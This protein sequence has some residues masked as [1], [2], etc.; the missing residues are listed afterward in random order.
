MVKT[1]HTGLSQ[2]G[3]TLIESM[4]AILISSI[5]AIAVGTIVVT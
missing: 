5:V 2:D 3:F 4:I 1:K